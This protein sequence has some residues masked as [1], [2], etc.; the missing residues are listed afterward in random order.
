MSLTISDGNTPQAS[1]YSSMAMDLAS[2][3]GLSSE[4]RRSK[5]DALLEERRRCY[6]SIVLLK[7]LYVSHTGTFC[8]VRDEKTPGFPQSPHTPA[9][10]GSQMTDAALEQP[11]STNN[12]QASTD[13]GV[14]A[15]VLQLSGIWQKTIRHAHRRGKTNG[16]PPWS[17]RSDYSQIVE[18]IMD[19]ETTL[20][21][22]YRSRPARFAEQD[23]TRLHENRDFWGS[24][25]FLQML[26]HTILCLLNHPLLMSLR[27]RSFRVNMVPEVFLQHTADLT[28]THTEWIIHLL[29]LCEKKEFDIH[30]QFFAHSAAIVATIYLQQSYSEDFAI[31]STKQECFRKCVAFIKRLGRYSPHIDQLVSHTSLPTLV[32][33][34][35][36]PN[37]TLRHLR[38]N[39]LSGLFRIPIKSR[40][41]SGIL[42]LGYSLI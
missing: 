24:W 8:F 30:N 19:S 14:I 29:S 26:Y 13:L 7:H 37:T 10:M 38:S 32:R 27:L 17:I 28:A 18:E 4:D 20:P 40:H 36:E 42:T 33:F 12:S 41:H 16:V 34:A 35:I 23:A 2:S 6:W 11:E 25:L 5:S 3:S 39:A 21:Y 31:R 15:Y 22:K 1:T 9:S